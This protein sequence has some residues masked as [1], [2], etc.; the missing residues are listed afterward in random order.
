MEFVSHHRSIPAI[1]GQVRYLRKCGYNIPQS[2]CFWTPKE[3]AILAEDYPQYGRNSTRLLSIGYT[4]EQIDQK[5][6][7]EG[8]KFKEAMQWTPWTDEEDTWLKE[9]YNKEVSIS[10]LISLFKEAFNNTSH[11]DA[12][13]KARMKTLRLSN[14]E[15]IRFWTT[16]EDDI[17]REYYPTI[18]TDCRKWLSGRSKV[19]VQTR[20]KIL[21]V[22]FIGAIRK[23]AKKIRCVETDLLFDSVRSAACWATGKQCRD[24]GSIGV[25]LNRPSSDGAKA[26]GYHWEYVEE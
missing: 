4:K 13:I 9:H 14:I 8:I 16:A 12:A 11:T 24:G 23:N 5:A 17:I 3:V 1:H 21:G 18:G 10:Y 7:R 20:A 26:Y 2:D 15:N 22:S 19:H 6:K 25:A